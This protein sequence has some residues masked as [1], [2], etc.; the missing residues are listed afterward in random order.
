[1]AYRGNQLREHLAELPHL[2]QARI[3][4]VAEVPL[5]KGT[6]PHKLDIVLPQE[7]KIGDFLGALFIMLN[8]SVRHF[9]KLN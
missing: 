4:I 7:L 3:R 8:L 1:M 2:H 5:R 6:Q 9:G